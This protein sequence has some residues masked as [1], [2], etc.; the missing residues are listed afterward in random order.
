MH[1]EAD[2]A[3]S[4][5][6]QENSSEKAPPSTPNKAE[7]I[8]VFDQDDTCQLPEALYIPKS[9]DGTYTPPG[10]DPTLLKA[11][12]GASADDLDY[13]CRN[14]YDPV[15]GFTDVF[16]YNVNGE[17]GTWQQEFTASQ[18]EKLKQLERMKAGEVLAP[19]EVPRFASYL[20]KEVPENGNRGCGGLADRMSGK[21]GIN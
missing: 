16:P 10:P 11:L 4:Q 5:Q 9:E 6:Q 19:E 15:H 21:L 20:C 1:Q 12:R 18:N 2:I 14:V 7:D 8:D 17:C 13:Y 3:D